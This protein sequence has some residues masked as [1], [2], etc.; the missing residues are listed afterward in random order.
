M[1]NKR[2]V[3]FGRTESGDALV[4]IIWDE[5]PPHHVVDDAYRELYPDEYRF[6]GHV[7]WTAAEAEEGVILHD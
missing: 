6:V 4:P 7:N 3:T 1:S 2:W 5:R